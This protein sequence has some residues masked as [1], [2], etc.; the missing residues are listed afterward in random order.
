M[1][2]LAWWWNYAE[3]NKCLEEIFTICTSWFAD[4]WL[5]FI[6][7]TA[8]HLTMPFHMKVMKHAIPQTH[9]S[10]LPSRL[11][12]AFFLYLQ[13]TCSSLYLAQFWLFS[14]CRWII[15]LWRDFQHVLIWFQSSV[16]FRH[17][18]IHLT[19]CLSVYLFS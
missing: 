11:P 2:R 19:K 7:H 13:C 10:F 16:H 17:Q 18:I 9:S 3:Y 12:W 15:H 5:Y 6:E 14:D 4:F 8:A 1:A